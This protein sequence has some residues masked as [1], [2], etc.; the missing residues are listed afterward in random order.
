MEDKDIIVNDIEYNRNMNI[1]F[2]KWM[3]SGDKAEKYPQ[4]LYSLLRDRVGSTISGFNIGAVM[5][6]HEHEM[7]FNQI[8]KI[9]PGIPLSVYKSIVSGRINLEA[10]H[11]Y[12]WL[13]ENYPEQIEALYNIFLDS[14]KSN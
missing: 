12:K 7:R 13:R 9:I 2:D 8:K 6:M 10:V 3:D 1:E 4:E 11:L 5:Y 14:N